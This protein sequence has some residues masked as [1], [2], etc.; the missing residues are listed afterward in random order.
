MYYGFLW[1]QVLIQQ[2]V[3]NRLNVTYYIASWMSNSDLSPKICVP[4]ET[5]DVKYLI[6]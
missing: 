6:W 5:K 3:F 4:S 1:N 2:G